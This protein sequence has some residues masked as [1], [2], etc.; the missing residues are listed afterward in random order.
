MYKVI[1]ITLRNYKAFMITNK[2]IIKLLKLSRVFIGIIKL[3]TKGFI[4]DSLIKRMKR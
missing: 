3:I 4:K 1:F 2:V